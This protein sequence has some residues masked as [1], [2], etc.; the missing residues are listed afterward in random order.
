M[1][2]KTKFSL[3]TVFNIS[4][5]KIVISPDPKIIGKTIRVPI[6]LL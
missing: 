4:Y 2:Y 1:I 5:N 6:L 3:M